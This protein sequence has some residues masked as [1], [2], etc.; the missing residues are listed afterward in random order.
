M[1]RRI[2]VRDLTNAIRKNGYKK[3][4][5]HYYEYAW[6]RSN[7]FLSD[8]TLVA[9]CAIGQAAIVLGVEAGVLDEAFSKMIPFR[10]M[11]PINGII[12]DLNDFTDKSMGEIADEIESKYP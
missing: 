8:D 3:V 9:A 4:K 6:G 10:S 5:G 2:S 1:M 12:R 7:S 11:R